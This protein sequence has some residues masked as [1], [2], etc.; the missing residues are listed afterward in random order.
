VN[1]ASESH[2]GEALLVLA[3]LTNEYPQES[4][5]YYI[6]GTLLNQQ[7]RSREAEMVLRQHL[8]LAES[9][10]SGREQ[11][12]DALQ[13]QKRYAEAAAVLE[14]ALRINPDSAMLHQKL[15]YTYSRLERYDEAIEQ[16]RSALLDGARQA[17]AY[18]ALCD[19]LRRRGRR[20]EAAALLRQALLLYP[21][22][23]RLSSLLKEI[24]EAP[25]LK[26]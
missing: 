15:A 4:E 9:S 10:T 16:F 20:E 13:N 26:R 5:T 3:A 12:A 21:S 11:L 1:L 8:R 22:D 23:Q 19:L 7:G 17:D 6:M 2:F 14:E 25:P 24:E 18:A